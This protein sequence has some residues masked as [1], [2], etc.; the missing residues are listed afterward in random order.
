MH[1]MIGQE[2]N[3]RN[4]ILPVA[5][6]LTLSGCGD[7][8]QTSTEAMQT[9]GSASQSSTSSVGAEESLAQTKLAD[10]NL[11]DVRAV[12]DIANQLQATDRAAFMEYVISWKAAQVSEKVQAIM[13]ADG[14][15][16]ETI[17]E[18]VE[19]TKAAQAQHAV[20]DQKL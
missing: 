6:I 9:R 3:M 16:P 2:T 13:R 19:L 10:I 17:A 7:Q 15:A 4:M 18:A 12:G 20:G 11:F 14:T 8:V 5:A 1:P